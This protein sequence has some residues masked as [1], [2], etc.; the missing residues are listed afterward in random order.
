MICKTLRVYCAMLLS[1]E[2]N[3]RVI[4]ACVRKCASAWPRQS[5][6]TGLLLFSAC[7]EAPLVD[8]HLSATDASSSS[9]SSKSDKDAGATEEEEPSSSDD[10]G[11]DDVEA[12]DGSDEPAATPPSNPTTT[13][14]AV[15][16]GSRDGGT[17]SPAPGADSAGS[18]WWTSLFPTAGTGSTSPTTTSPTT[19]RDAGTKTTTSSTGSVGATCAT[20]PAYPTATACA[21]CICTKCSTQVATCYASGEATK[22]QQCAQI[23]ACAEQNH[24]VGDACYCGSDLLC[25]APTGPC[26]SAIQT[27]AGSTDSLDVSSA[28]SDPQS[29]VS[30]ASDLTTCA[31][32]SCSQE[33]GF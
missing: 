10:D 23:E 6:L 20:T 1:L 28:K 17:A 13:R 5:F 25:L 22:D 2:G 24:C 32:S 7:A 3:A 8:N 4:S 29:P 27:A 9:H 26:V 18:S 16:G 21:Q 11:D 30:R 15:N 12:D 31:S 33:C 19:S 14:G